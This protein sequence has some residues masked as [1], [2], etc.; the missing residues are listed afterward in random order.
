M[1]SIKPADVHLRAMLNSPARFTPA[2]PVPDWN[3]PTTSTAAPTTMV[4][5]S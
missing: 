2:V 4:N 3:T 5:I 1:E